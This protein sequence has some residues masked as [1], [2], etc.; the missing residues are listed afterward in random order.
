V[1]DVPEATA[2]L[3]VC[4][5]HLSGQ[6]LHPVMDSLGAVLVSLTRTAPAYRMVLL[7]GADHDRPGLIR[8]RDGGASVEVE[9]YRVPVA[10]LGALLV[11]VGSPLAIGSVL[12]DDGSLVHGFVCEGFVDDEATD[13]TS[14][15]S[16]RTYL[17]AAV[18]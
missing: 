6:P 13:I 18:S 12:L 2:L 11:T 1:T 5:A 16:W 3:A 15:G 10:G 8:C 9:V 14:F 7:S 4:G 17:G